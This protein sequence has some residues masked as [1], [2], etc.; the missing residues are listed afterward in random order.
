MDMRRKKVLSLLLALAMM[1]SLTA[2]SAGE[3]VADTQ[4]TV[5]ET[6][7]SGEE[8]SA[9]TA[10]SEEGTEEETSGAEA[11]ETETA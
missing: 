8:V 7:V 1:L 2:C 6:D 4:A 3:P 11:V 9:E 5:S 10:I